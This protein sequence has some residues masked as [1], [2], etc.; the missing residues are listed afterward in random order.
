MD[1]IPLSPAAEATPAKGKLAVCLAGLQ[2]GMVGVLW[3][4]AWMGVSSALQQRSFWTAENL[5]AT[6]LYGGSA[7]RPG[8]A[9]TTFF[10]LALYLLLYSFLGALFAVTVRQRLSRN[11]TLLAAVLLGVGWYFV[12]FH[13][14]WKSAIPLAFLLH[15]EQPTILGHLIYGTFLGRFPVYLEE[16]RPAGPDAPHPPSS[17]EDVEAAPSGTAPPETV[18]ELSATLAES[19]VA[20]SSDPDAATAP[21]TPAP[22][23][24]S[25]PQD[26]V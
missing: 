23:Q 12:S 16:P 21:A 5:F 20:D 14:I 6:S 15:S 19:S 3:M 26:P 7:I 1:G 11:R 24:S 13:W 9:H 8:F 17:T 4:L 18:S 22:T 10:G 25:L 2:S